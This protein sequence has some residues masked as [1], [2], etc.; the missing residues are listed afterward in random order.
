MRQAHTHT[1]SADA[2]ERVN[3]YSHDGH[4]PNMNVS[5]GAP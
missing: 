2:D 3:E 1:H 5:K 4:T